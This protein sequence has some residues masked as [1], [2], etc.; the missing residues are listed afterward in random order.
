AEFDTLEINTT[1]YRTPSQE[2]VAAWYRNTPA[3]FPVRHQR[4][5]IHHAYQVE[6]AG[7]SAPV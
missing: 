4:Q 5:P 7:R 3:R 2:T 1:F 6:G